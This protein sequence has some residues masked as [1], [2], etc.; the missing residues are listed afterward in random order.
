MKTKLAPLPSQKQPLRYRQF[1]AGL[2]PM[3]ALADAKGLVLLAFQDGEDPTMPESNW[4]EDR[5]GFKP[6]I[7]AL[8]DY[9][10]GKGPLP[11]WPTGDIKGTPFQRKVWAALK[12]IPYGEVRSYGDVAKMIG[13]PLAARAV[14]GACGKNPLPL[15]VPCHRV[16][17]SGGRIGGF[18]CGL[19]V[20]RRLMAIEGLSG[21]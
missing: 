1:D 13:E 12:R 18:G 14:G 6:L 15:F 3:L 21:Y 2:G 5:D 9:A 20:K 17:A 7:A 4:L 8:K 16:I 19:Q 10:K 11:P